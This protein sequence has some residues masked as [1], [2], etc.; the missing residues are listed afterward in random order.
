MYL[1]PLQKANKHRR[2]KLF[3]VMVGAVVLGFGVWHIWGRTEPR[4][5]VWKQRRAMEQARAFIEK[6]DAVRAQI[7]LE[8]ALTT[9]PGNPDA[10]RLAAELLELVGSPQALRMR[11]AVVRILPDSAGDAAALVMCSLRF[12]DINMARDALS[13]MSPSLANQV[14]TLRAA[15]AFALATNNSPVSDLLFE[16]LKSLSPHDDGLKFTHAL[17]LLKHPNPKRQAEAR[18]QLD[19]LIKSKPQFAIQAY[20]ELAGYAMQEG[21]FEDARKLL[22]LV[23]ADP[24]ANFPD[25]LQLANIEL[26][27]DK[28]PFAEVFDQMASLASVDPKNVNIFIQWLMVQDRSLEAEKWLGHLPEKMLQDGEVRSVQADLAARLQGW[29][30][31]ARL[32]E[33]GA[34]GPVTHDT[35]GLAMTAR[36]MDAVARPDL[37]KETWEEALNSANNQL[38]AL[39]VLYKLASVW[40]WDEQVDQTL[41][42]I[43][44]NFSDQTWAHQQLFNSY[45][46]KGN[47][48]GLREVTGTLRTADINMPRYQH[49]WALLTLLTEPSRTM[50]HA[51]E[52]MRQ[53]HDTEPSNPNFTTGYAFALAQL[54]RTDEALDLIQ[55]LSD[56]DRGYPPRQPYLAFIYGSCH[57]GAELQKAQTLAKGIRLLPE[58]ERLLVLANEEMKRPINTAP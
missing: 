56:S 55:K 45:R 53:L 19:E 11:Q 30:H 25:R 17:L 15:L 40:G 36:A 22:T 47:T 51:K 13:A 43:A 33:G 57:K 28:K 39:R 23:L 35:V 44:R 50:T 38:V 32:L 8:V 9:V 16:K 6:H 42:K 14:P 21:K 12:H 2:V 10:I 1:L 27:I 54:G 20:R 37:R 4:Y 7:A 34:W 52:V 58:E 3:F 31:L 41:W 26:L 48:A 5:R 46:S 18:L 29:D 49:D 24:K